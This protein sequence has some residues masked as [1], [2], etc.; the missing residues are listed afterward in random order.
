[1]AEDRLWTSLRNKQLANQKF[2]RQVSIGQYIVDFYSPK[3]RLVIEVDGGIHRD[4]EVKTNDISRQEFLESLDLK[5]LRFTNF[6]VIH[7]IE[8]VLETIK[9][10]LLNPLFRCE[11]EGAQGVR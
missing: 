3:N 9:T 10:V 4:P 7:R 1:M 5:V 8:V 6:D 11:G 2:R